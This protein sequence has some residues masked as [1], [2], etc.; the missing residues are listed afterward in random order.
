VALNQQAETAAN[1]R[2]AAVEAA[3]GHPQT[4]WDN[5]RDRVQNQG[6]KL[7]SDVADEWLELIWCLDA[8]RKAQAPPK[9]MGKATVAWDLRLQGV[10]R[11]KGNWFATLLSLLLD[12]RTGQTIR[13]RGNIKGFSQVHQIDL[14]WPDRDVDPLVCAEC[15]VSGAPGFDTTPSR[16]M[17]DFAS[18][19]KELKFAATDLKLARRSQSTSIGHWDVWRRSAFPKTFLLWG[20]RPG[21]SDTVKKIAAQAEALVKTYLDGAGVFVWEEN[22]GGTGYRPVPLPSGYLV[23]ELDDV[24]W[25]IE[26]EIKANVQA[27]GAAPPI[28]QL[29][30]PVNPP[31]TP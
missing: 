9:G 27:T 24:L 13:S 28:Q 22:A 29:A 30:I 20:V 25:Q 31:Q 6:T 10:Y 12:N 15:K 8:Y 23:V 4:R 16:G 14:A 17:D 3:E 2:A 21:P 7:F 1:A 18:R 11:G 26:S 19:R 5:L